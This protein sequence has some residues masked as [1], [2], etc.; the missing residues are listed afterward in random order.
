M[1][2]LYEMFQQVTDER[3]FSEFLTALR[4]DCEWHERHCD[5]RDPIRCA[6]GQHIQSHSTTDFL[7]SMEEWSQGDFADGSHG[8][9][10]V[11]QR[12]AAMLWVGRMR[13]RPKPDE[14][15]RDWD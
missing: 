8:G 1:H 13:T 15:E 5:R 4:K 7:R 11:L 6:E 10:P 3:S 14:D 9:A 12:V 2:P